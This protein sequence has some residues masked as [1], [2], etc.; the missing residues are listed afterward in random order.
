LFG[1]GLFAAGITSS[2]TA[3]LAAAFGIREIFGWP[4]DP[5]DRRFRTVWISVLLTGLIF[6]L[7]GRN[8]LEIIIAA[9]A[10][11][12]LLLPLMAA[13][14]LLL[15]ARQREVTLP[16]WYKGVGMVVVLVTAGLG[17]RT[18]LWVFEQLGY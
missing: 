4:D 11:N 15:T 18:L 8:P 12:G 6:A 7:I 9:Q 2:V 14:V 1:L 13:F 5:R 3:P 16:T 17:I 10:A